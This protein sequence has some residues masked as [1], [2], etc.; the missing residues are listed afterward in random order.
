MSGPLPGTPSVKECGGQSWGMPC[1]LDHPPHQALVPALN[2]GGKGPWLCGRAAVLLV[3]AS[4]LI[5][6]A[7]LGRGT[8]LFVPRFPDQSHTSSP[9]GRLEGQ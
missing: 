4:L 6:G 9:A 7:T 1:L 3:P 8:N 2:G 5:H